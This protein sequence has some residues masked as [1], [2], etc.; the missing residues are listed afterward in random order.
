M[1][2]HLRG[3][4]VCACVQ[5]INKEANHTGRDTLN[6]IGVDP[7][8]LLSGEDCHK[9]SLYTRF[10]LAKIRALSARMPCRKTIVKTPFDLIHAV[11]KLPSLLD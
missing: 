11:D 7:V 10:G 4:Y 6:H 2:V 1:C 9:P 8:H 3:Q 5:I